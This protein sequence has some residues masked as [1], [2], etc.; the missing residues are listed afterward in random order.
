MTYSDCKQYDEALK[1]YE[2]ELKFRKG[3]LK[4]VILFLE[5]Q[6]EL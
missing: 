6:K 2:M 1:F 3:E 5:S 4:E